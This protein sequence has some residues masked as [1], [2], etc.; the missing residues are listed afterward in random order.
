MKHRLA[1]VLMFSVAL[2]AGC[3]RPSSAELLNTWATHLEAGEY[4]KAKALMYRPSF[5]WQEVTQSQLQKYTWKNHRLF[6]VPAAEQT[7][8]TKGSQRMQWEIVKPSGATE[9]LC[10]DVLIKDGKISADRAT[11]CQANAKYG[12]KP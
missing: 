6:D 12:S 11:T 5:D 8:M 4:D 9:Y 10:T 1:L 3:G 2:L 7:A